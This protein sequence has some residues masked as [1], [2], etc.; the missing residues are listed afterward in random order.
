MLSLIHILT[1][2]N[3][4]RAE[5]LQQ[6]ICTTTKGAHTLNDIEY[7]FF[8]ICYIYSCQRLSLTPLARR[9]QMRKVQRGSIQTTTAGR[10]RYYDEYLARCV[11]EVSSVFDVVASRR[12]VPNNITDKN[13]VRARILSL[14]GDKKVRVLWYTVE[15]DKM[16]VPVITKK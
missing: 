14:A 10:K 1:T 13:R 11:D 12:A 7:T 15:N 2:Q 4:W 8:I 3:R 9:K 16:A 6:K 5:L